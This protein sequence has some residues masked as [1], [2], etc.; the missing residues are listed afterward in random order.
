M[1]QLFCSLIP[2]ILGACTVFGQTGKDSLPHPLI[3][4]DNYFNHEIHKKTGKLYHYTWEDTE[5]SGFSGWG[6]IFSET[7]FT[8]STLGTAPDKQQL[9]KAAVYLIVDPD[10]ARETATPHFIDKESIRTITSWV[11]KGGILVL[12]AN[13][14]GN[15]EFTHLNELA[16]CF[17]FRLNEVRRNI[18]GAGNVNMEKATFR[19]FPDHPFFTGVKAV[20]IKEICTLTLPKSAEVIFSEGGDDLIAVIRAGKGKVLVFPDPWFYNEYLNGE[21]RCRLTDAYQNDVAAR[22]IAGWLYREAEKK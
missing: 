15:C 9:R 16:A 8:L 20:F 2:L 11:R 10:D 13:D 19:V 3:L 22:N 7:G 14:S 1:K 4:L 12:M 18:P 6:R 17:G 21:A 5:N